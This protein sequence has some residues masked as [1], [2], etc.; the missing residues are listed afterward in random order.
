L[1][2]DPYSLLILAGINVTFS[3]VTGGI[4][5]AILIVVVLLI[6]SAVISGSEV[7]FFSLSP[8]DLS[9]ITGR[10]TKRSQ[11]ILNTLRKPRRLL[12]TILI[13]NNFINVGIVIISSFIMTSTID[14]TGSQ[15]LEFIIQVVVVTFI[16][17]L[18][19]EILPKFYANQHAVKFA[20][21]M[22]FPLRVFEKIFYPLS[23]FLI[24]STSIVNNRIKKRQNISMDDLSDALEITADDI[25]EDKDILEGI[26]KFGNIDVSEIMKARIDVVAV[27][28]KTKLS[29]LIGVVVNSGFS[30]IPIYSEN[31]DNIKGVLYIKDLLPHLHKSDSFKWQS[32]IRPPYYVPENKKIDDLLREF[33][34]KKIHLA[35]VID[36]YGGTY[37]IVTLEDIIEEIVGEIRD[38][39]DEEEF[40][41]KKVDD[42]TWLFDGKTPLIDFFKIVDMSPELF[43]DVK[44]DADTLAGLLLE[45]KGAIPDKDEEFVIHDIKFKVESVDKRR[46]KEIIV[47]RE[48]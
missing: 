23:S 1:E 38:E 25:K 26:I 5:A 24:F 46:I 31:P 6:G 7:A 21:F 47:N 4:F 37:G 48:S 19:G 14:L 20:M 12:G 3:P 45:S 8:S 27:D 9:D 42:S 32:L 15:A 35:I 16:L 34:T 11:A 36:E 30:R 29:E 17:L 18:F 44:G 13:T 33:Q 43:D 28:I 40:I 22:V 39:S 10:G 41:F 2:T